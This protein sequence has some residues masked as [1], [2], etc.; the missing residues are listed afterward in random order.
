MGD[1]QGFV[2]LISVLNMLTYLGGYSVGVPPLTIPNREV[3]PDCADG[4]AV[5]VGEQVAA[6]FK[7]ETH[8]RVSLFFLLLREKCFLYRLTFSLYLYE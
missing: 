4:T 1:F 5:F 3:K 7:R 2:H 6:D 8:N